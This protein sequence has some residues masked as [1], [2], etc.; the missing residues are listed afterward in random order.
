MDV[1][2][3]GAGVISLASA[4]LLAEPGTG[5]QVGNAFPK[6]SNIGD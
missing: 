4:L 3:I 5:V 1:G 6:I 2:M